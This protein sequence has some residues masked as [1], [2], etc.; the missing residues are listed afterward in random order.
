[1]FDISNL[2]GREIV[3]SMT[4]FE[5]GLPKRAHYRSFGIRGQ[6]GQDDFAAIGEVI[7]R[8]FARLRE[9]TD[10]SFGRT[11]NRV[12]IDGAKGRLSADAPSSSTSARQSASWR[13]PR[14][15]SRACPACPPR[16]HGL[17]T[18]NSTRQVAGRRGRQGDAEPYAAS[19]VPPAST[20]RRKRN[21][22]SVAKI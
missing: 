19:S 20:W 22:R 17:C 7:S 13:R 12:G 21:V 14:R 2:Q 6:E 9:G 5:D 16:P 3:G 11:P 15:S 8:R 4:V 18:R 1:C 10:D